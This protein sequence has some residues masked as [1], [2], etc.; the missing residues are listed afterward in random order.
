MASSQFTLFPKKA[1]AFF[2][3]TVDPAT[4]A[5]WVKEYV[6]DP[7]AWIAVKAVSRGII[8]SLTNWIATGFEGGPFFVT[9]PEEFFLEV[10][11]RVAGDFIKSQGFGSICSP[12]R[13]QIQLAVIRAYSESRIRSRI[14]DRQSCTLSTALGNVDAFLSGNFS[15]G[16]WEQWFSVTQNP[17]NNPYGATFNITGELARRVAQEAGVELTEIGW[18]DGFLSVKDCIRRVNPTDPNSKCAEFGN[19]KTPGVV[20]EEKLNL[21]LGS[22]TR[23]LEIADELSE[24]I[25]ALFNQVIGKVFSAGSDLFGG[26]GS[27]A[28]DFDP[29]DID[30]N[31]PTTL[32]VFILGG[33]TITM[34]TGTEFYDPGAYALDPTDGYISS[35]SATGNVDPAVPGTYFITYT[36]TNSLGQSASATRT[37]TVQDQAAPPPPGGDDTGTTN[38]SPTIKLAG[39]STV[40][41]PINGLYIEPGFAAFDAEDGDITAN[42]FCTMGSFT[43]DCYNIGNFIDTSVPGSYTIR[44]EVVDSGGMKFLEARFVQVG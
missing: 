34:P 41:V 25:S 39:S 17:Q 35:V 4:I 37:V 11:D 1:E 42:V 20:I 43:G 3:P 13:N 38:S 40:V 33:D 16:G 31:R 9:N 6:L 24:A 14:F 10:G 32:T 19:P 15:Q 7:A 27:E 26:A 36:A 2:V 21:A 28:G 12:F 30:P 23:T 8:R 5:L 22:D 44:Y 18:A 29:R